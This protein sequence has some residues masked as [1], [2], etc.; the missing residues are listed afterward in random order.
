VTRKLEGRIAVVTGAARGIGRAIAERFSAEGA[1]V[2]LADLDGDAAQE[3]A[4]AITDVGGTAIGVGTDVGDPASVDRLFQITADEL[5]TVSAL[6]NNAAITTDVRHVFH[7][8]QEWWD[9]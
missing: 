7:G 3:A 8:D 2:A 6:V 4:R 1:H 5:G 9:R